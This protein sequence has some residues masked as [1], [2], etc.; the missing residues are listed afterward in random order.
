MVAVK[1]QQVDRFLKSIDLAIACCVVYG[2]DPGGISELAGQAARAFAK[3]SDPPGEIIRIDDQDLDTDP[4][5]L[6]V[7]LQTIPMFGGA[8]VVRTAVSRRINATMLKPILEGAPPA[9]ALIIEAGNLKPSDALRKL[10]EKTAW[11]AALPSYI[12]NDRD[13]AALIDDVIGA[14]GLKISPD[15]REL[16]MGRLGADRALSRNEIEKLTLFAHGAT[17][18]EVNDVAAVIGDASAVSLDKLT[19]AVIAGDARSALEAQQ[20]AEAAGQTA[21]SMLLALQRQFIALH[22]LGAAVS[23]GKRV[24]EAI[25][26]MRPPLHFSVRDQ[27]TAALRRWQIGA[28]NRA[29]QRIQSSITETRLNGALE[30][31]TTERLVLE[32]CQLAKQSKAA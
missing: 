31:S 16:L 14:A 15:A 2:T 8:K 26:S 21:Q 1:A 17:T 22:R 28:L 3:R 13:I 11:A 24:D 23:S 12:D 20:Q 6:L 7:E 30:R 32:L 27:F 10:A 25:R 19:L 18:I 4:D 5:K 29:V 9:A